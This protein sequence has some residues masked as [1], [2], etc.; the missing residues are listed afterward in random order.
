MESEG[1]TLAVD[2]ADTGQ[3]RST[4]ECGH[5]SCEQ[6][7]QEILP[8]NI[9]VQGEMFHQPGRILIEESQ[10]SVES[11]RLST[12]DPLI[13]NDMP[14]SPPPNHAVY[15]WEP[16]EEGRVSFEEAIRRLN[17]SEPED[18]VFKFEELHGCDEAYKEHRHQFIDAVSTCQSLKNLTIRAFSQKLKIEEVQRLC[19][20]LLPALNSLELKGIFDYDVVQIVCE[21]MANNCVLKNL[22]LRIWLEGRM[23]SA[24]ASLGSML[25]INST[26]DSL[27][28]EGTDLGPN[29]VEAL[30]QPLTGHATARPLNK[31]LAHLLIGGLDF[32]MGQGAGEAIAHMLRTNDTLTHF[33][34][35]AGNGLEPSDVCKI[36]ESLQ[37]NQTLLSLSLRHC[38]GV[39]GPDVSAKMMDLF[40]MNHSLTN[41]DLGWT[42]LEQSDVCKILE[43]LQKNQTL[44]Y[45]GLSR[46]EGVKGPDVLAKMMD[47]V[48]MHPCLM[49]INLHDTPLEREGQAA[50]VQAQLENNA[51][52]YMAVL[53]GMPRVPPKFV[54]VFLCGNAYAGKTTLGRSM[55]RAFANGCGPNL[56]LSLTEVIELR[57]PFKFC[58]TDPDEWSKRTRGIE[59]NVLLDHANQKISLWDLAG[60]EEYHAFHDMMMPD[61]SSQGNVSFFLLVCNPFDRESGKRKSPETIKEELRS[62]LRFIS[63]NTKRSFNFPPHITIVMTNA[64]KGL[65]HK[66]FVES[67]V[68]EL[69]NQF[70]KYIN[71][72]SKLHS[73]NAHSSQQARHVVDDVTTTCTNVLH[74]LPYVFEA[75]VNVQHGLSDWIKEH[76][77]QPTIAMETFKNDIM[78]KK[79]LRL[80]PMS[81]T[82]THDKHL[83]PHEAVALFLH[84]AGE[85]IYF[86]DEDFVVVNPHWFCHQVMGHLIEL[87]R[88]VEELELT[89]TFHGGFMTMDQIESLLKS[90]FKNATHWVGMDEGKVF[91]NL[92][93]LMIKMDLAYKDD[94]ADHLGD[95][96]AYLPS[97][98]RLFVPATLE[99]ETVVARGERR[100][101]WSVQFHVQAIYIG[102]RLQCRDEDVTTLTPGFFPRV[103]VVLK[104]RF[105]DLK[106]GIIC[107]NEKNLMKICVNGLEIFVELSG[108]Q[109][110]GHAFIDILVKSSKNEIQTIQL[111]HDHVLSPI[112]HLCNS[113]QGCQGVTLMRG[114]LRPRAVEKLLLCKN[115]T[116]QV[117]WVENLKEELLATNLDFELVH[118]WPQVDVQGN[119]FLHASMEDKVASLLGQVATH[120]VLERHLEGLKDVEI[121]I[122]NLPSSE[123][124]SEHT[125]GETSESGD[126]RLERSFHQ[127]S[128][129]EPTNLEQFIRDIMR[130][131]LRSSEER[132]VARISTKLEEVFAKT[133]QEI[134]C[135]EEWLYNKLSKK[136]DGMT[137]LFLQLHQQQVPCN[138]FFTT[139]GTRQQRRLVD[140]LMGIGIIYLHFLCEDIDGIH[141]VDD[142]KGD[143]IRYVEDENRHKIAHL[144]IVGFKIVSILL[145]VAAHVVGGVGNLVPDFAQGLALAYDAQDITNCIEDPRIHGGP[146]LGESSTSHLPTMKD[147]LVEEH[148]VA[149]QWLVDFLRRKDIFKLFG[150]S[151]VKYM[152][153]KHGDFSPIRWVC[154]HHRKE[155]LKN[156][157]LE[158]C[159]A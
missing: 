69:A 80:Q 110:P 42:P 129:Q 127:M 150:L 142:Q 119:D 43:S 135:M 9:I 39:K 14:A 30:L 108:N 55:K 152:D 23:S 3:G 36:L 20:N 89:T 6:T 72:S 138:A 47:L 82:D 154:L 128:L 98:D 28:L 147:A 95:H 140:G 114:V 17:E 15:L 68:K 7:A 46:C 45:L 29:G 126:L 22:S 19:Q 34:I 71:L 151:R 33:A 54:R 104:H 103:Q 79:E 48:R 113:P 99:L 93:Q 53:R 125:Q 94:M 81:P 100:L 4:S 66:E 139:G 137:K 87:R 107:E 121:D 83:N 148:K 149:T 115:R 70:R 144:V 24:G 131:E 92:I 58:S 74:K 106:M 25:A 122:N 62:W 21:K 136:L 123:Q 8:V 117:A 1:L 56:F 97:N 118:P 41:I 65:I 146:I 67:D 112:E 130:A 156:G 10:G 35:L 91:Q 31:S 132:I 145:K 158:D 50:Q 73:I 11:D 84:D 59:I 26:L 44:R 155:G 96:V 61:L 90:S 49:E 5:S 38:G 63:S 77:Y 133:K 57:K 102:R 86:K 120:D 105:A 13:H 157:T 18:L 124:E 143:E 37:K 2:A 159:P 78:A 60:Q 101:Q 153:S 51:K 16:G 76:P 111:V 109:M 12:L 75:C 116:K 141:V 134:K 27:D 32:P 85:I 52:D 88:H 64:D 40:R